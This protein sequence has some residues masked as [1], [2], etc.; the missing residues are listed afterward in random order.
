MN[1]RSF[2]FPRLV[3]IGAFAFIVALSVRASSQSSPA[4][5]EPDRAAF[6]VKLAQVSFEDKA[7]RVLRLLGPPDD[8]R[9]APD[10]VPYPT[11]E[12]WCYGTNGHNS[13]ATLG[14]V[15]LRQGGVIWVAGGHGVSPLQSVIGEDELRGDALPPS[16]SGACRLQ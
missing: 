4:K 8:I 2:W 16:W 6:T 9:R 13:L 11:D 3:S 14:E 10:P 5:P 1:A 15:C 12:I 7:E